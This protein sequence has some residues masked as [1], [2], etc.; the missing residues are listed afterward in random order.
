MRAAEWGAVTGTRAYH[1]ATKH[2]WQS[3]RSGGHVL[4]WE[5]KPFPFKIYPDAP[6]LLLPREVPTPVRPAL[7]ALTQVYAQ[8]GRGILDLSALAQLLFFAAGLTKK[9][10]YPGGEG[11]HFRAAAST[12]ALYEVELYLVVAEV[13]GLE[14]GVYHFSPGDFSLRRLRAGDHRAALSDAAG[15]PDAVRGAPATLVLSAI[16]W[17]NTW[18]YQARAFRHFF[19][20]A[21]TLLANLLATA[22]AA[23]VPA[24]VLLGF[25]DADVNALLGLDQAREGSL[26]LVPL[27]AGAGPG[28]AAPPRPPL[29]LSTIPLSSREVDY[30]LVREAYL[31]S[32]LATGT[33]ARAWVA[34]PEHPKP[35]T[36]GSEA[37]SYALAPLP[38]PPA[39]PLGTV[40]LRRGSTRQFGRES[41]GF[42]ELSTLLDAAVRDL[43]L[44]VGGS[45]SALVD[46]Y[47]LIHAVD[48]VPPGAYVYGP[49]SGELRQLRAGEFRA[50]GGYLCLE[51]SLGADASVVVFFLA[52]LGS[53]LARYGDRGYRAVNLAAGLYGGRMYLAAYALGAGASGLTFYDDD[54]VRFFSPDA[55]GKDAIFV[56]ALGRAR[57]ASPP[58]GLRQVEGE[59]RP[60]RPGEP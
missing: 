25:A 33:A 7:D 15:E 30:P 21:G 48:G 45:A 17:R 9:K 10:V 8:P 23:D 24:R 5:T 54:V 20:D 12:G 46:C 50:E 18:K 55:A 6:A 52:D 37:L 42:A 1:D 32:S 27:G 41:I 28:P 35:A 3:V 13:V 39:A 51:Q 26:V 59:L 2:S 16:Y 14:P 11:V 56:T 53:V 47:L 31:A 38:S 60:L 22:V 34:Q 44:D 43:P 40:I 49:A 19:W 29:A 57:R 36:R 4:D 58:A